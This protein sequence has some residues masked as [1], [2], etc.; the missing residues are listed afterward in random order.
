M[1]SWHIATFRTKWYRGIPEFRNDYNFTHFHHFIFKK[2]GF[3]LYNKE[4]C[5]FIFTTALKMEVAYL[6]ETLVTAFKAI[7]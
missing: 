2:P 3:V 5:Y 7:P 4:M 1:G 6:S